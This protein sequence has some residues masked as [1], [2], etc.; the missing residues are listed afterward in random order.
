MA[1]EGVLGK[2]DPGEGVRGSRKICL[3]DLRVEGVSSSNSGFQWV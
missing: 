3:K 1:G 2:S